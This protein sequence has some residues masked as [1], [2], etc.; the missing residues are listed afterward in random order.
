MAECVH[1]GRSHNLP[2]L[3]QNPRGVQVLESRQIAA[4]QLLSSADDTLQSALILGSG[5]SI[6]DGDGGGEDGLND[7]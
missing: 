5:S 1:G 2:C 7:V 3:P 6:P 4:D